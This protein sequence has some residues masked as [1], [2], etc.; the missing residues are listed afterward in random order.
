MVYFRRF[1]DCSFDIFDVSLQ[2]SMFL[3]D[4]RCF[5]TI[6]DDF[7]V[8]F[9]VLFFVSH[10]YSFFDCFAF[11]FCCLNLVLQISSDPPITQVHQI[12]IALRRFNF[13][14]SSFQTLS[15]HIR[16]ITET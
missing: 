7:D 4:F 15:R 12:V 11:L 2:F 3:T 9:T 13:V 8:F 14:A 16:H 10:T 5:S 6:F 1:F